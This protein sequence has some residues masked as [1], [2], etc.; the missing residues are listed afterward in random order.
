M[1]RLIHKADQLIPALRPDWCSNPLAWILKILFSLILSRFSDP[2]LT[3]SSKLHLTLNLCPRHRKL[4]EEVSGV[5][6]PPSLCCFPCLKCPSFP[7][8][9]VALQKASLTE[10]YPVAS[11][12]AVFHVHIM[13]HFLNVHL[14]FHCLHTAM[15]PLLLLYPQINSAKSWINIFSMFTEWWITNAWMEIL[16]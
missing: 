16:F 5:Y 6:W 15:S 2:A 13:L 8:F 3:S 14:H 10:S 9:P 12:L 4:L 7:S 1:I 11:L